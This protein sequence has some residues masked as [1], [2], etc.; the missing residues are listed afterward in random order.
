MDRI[1]LIGM[2]HEGRFGA[3]EEERAMP[4]LL[5]VDLEV[6]ADLAAAS[7]SDLLADTIDYAP[8]V[9]IVADTVERGSYK[10]ME[11][12]GGAIISRALE[13][14]PAAHS[15][16]VRVR[17]LAVPMDVD[18]DYAGVELHRQRS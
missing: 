18:M 15:M 11:A 1:M 5:E 9:A 7:E 14:A 10:L 6:T 8:L 17:K 13:A 2:R 12:L 3:T 16:T 4:Q